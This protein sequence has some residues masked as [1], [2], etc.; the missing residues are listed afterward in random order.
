[1]CQYAR[2]DECNS[3]RF[4]T[5]GIND[6][7]DINKKKKKKKSVITHLLLLPEDWSLLKR[8][9]KSQSVNEK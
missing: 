1:M 6:E 2:S 5:V 8:E 7:E 4:N 3:N 9:E